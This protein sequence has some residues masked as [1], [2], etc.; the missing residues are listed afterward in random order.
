V[1]TALGESRLYILRGIVGSQVLRG[2]FPMTV[3]EQNEAMLLNLW[4]IGEAIM[5]HDGTTIQKIQEAVERV[6]PITGGEWF[7]FLNEGRT[8][9]P[10]YDSEAEKYWEDR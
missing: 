9:E 2:E 6:Q 4:K 10:D 8:D 7:R 5:P 3:Q 1:R